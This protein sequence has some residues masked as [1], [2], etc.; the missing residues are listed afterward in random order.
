VLARGNIGTISMPPPN[1]TMPEECAI[2][3]VVPADA[4]GLRMISRE[5]VTTGSEDPADHPL[6]ARGEESD[7]PLIF[8]NVFVPW[9]FMR[10]RCAPAL[11]PPWRLRNRPRA[12]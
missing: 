2:W 10:R 4:S 9:Q 7:S 8:D 12:G 11:L 3:S 1:P 6:D 5:P